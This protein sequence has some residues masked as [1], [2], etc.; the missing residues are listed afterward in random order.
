[1]TPGKDQIVLHA[2]E[3]FK[4]ALG[5]YAAANNTTMAAVIR[6]AVSGLI[7]YDLENEPSRTRTPKYASKAEATR[8]ALDRAA[9]LRWGNATTTKLLDKGEIAAASLIARAVNN[10]DYETLAL[11]KAA[12][13]PKPEEETPASD[14]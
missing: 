13:E 11:L 14:E 7:G 4:D 8:A 10:K 9:L 6:E 2:S 5:T 12:S 3:E 1:M